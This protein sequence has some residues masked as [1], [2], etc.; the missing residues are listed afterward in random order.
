MHFY[1]RTLVPHSL[2][3]FVTLVAQFVPTFLPDAKIQPSAISREVGR[4]NKGTHCC[5]TRVYMSSGLVKL[6]CPF[7]AGPRSCRGDL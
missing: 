2:L 4:I 1:N 6:T 3:P 7:R 5:M